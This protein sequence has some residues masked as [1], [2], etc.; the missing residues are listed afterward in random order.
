MNTSPFT[1]SRRP[2]SPH[3]PSA[4]CS[5]TETISWFGHSRRTL[6]L[7]THGTASKVLRTCSRSVVK[8]LP[9]ILPTT[10]LR[11]VSSFTC[12]RSSPYML[13]TRTARRVNIGR[14]DSH[15]SPDAT[16]AST[17]SA[18]IALAVAFRARTS[19]HISYP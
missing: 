2:S 16:H 10:P 3:V 18:V 12:C 8:K 6:A 14:C 4:S 17:V 9:L 7:R 13:S 5:S 15:H 11:T 19:C 1:D